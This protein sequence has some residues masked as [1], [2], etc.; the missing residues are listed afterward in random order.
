MADDCVGVWRGCG[1][2]RP[3]GGGL[4]GVLDTRLAIVVD[5]G[6][7]GIPKAR[8]SVYYLDR[9]PLSLRMSQ[10]TSTASPTR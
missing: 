8:C 4:V 6:A 9:R 2:G 10:F 5:G 3:S 1:A 7:L